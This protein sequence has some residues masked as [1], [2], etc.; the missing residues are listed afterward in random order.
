[1]QLRNYFGGNFGGTEVIL[2]DFYSG[3]GEQSELTEFKRNRDCERKKEAG[4]LQPSGRSK[5]THG[6]GWIDEDE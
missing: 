6:L 5:L 1:M 4:S 3:E 2:G